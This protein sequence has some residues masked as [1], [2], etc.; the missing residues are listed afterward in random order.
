MT[1]CFTGLSIGLIPFNSTSRDQISFPPKKRNLGQAKSVSD[2][3][4]ENVVHSQNIF[5]F[6]W[7]TYNIT[8][9]KKRG[10]IFALLNTAFSTREA[11]HS[12]GVFL[13]Y[14]L[15]IMEIVKHSAT[16]L[17]QEQRL[18]KFG[19]YCKLRLEIYR[20]SCS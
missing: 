14:V 3:Q 17:A 8:G 5:F 6:N 18:Y 11:Y 1:H 12:D 16:L 15:Q 20:T 2:H 13:I 4:R 10:E 7:Y 19:D 9:R